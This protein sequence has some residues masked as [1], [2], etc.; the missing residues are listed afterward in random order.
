M[1]VC[2]LFFL[3]FK[4]LSC[5]AQ[6]E[7]SIC[8]GF[9]KRKAY[10]PCDRSKTRHSGMNHCTSS[11]IQIKTFFFQWFQVDPH[12]PLLK[13]K[14]KSYIML[15]FLSWAFLHHPK[16]V[17]ALFPYLYSQ[18]HPLNFLCSFTVTTDFFPARLRPSPFFSR[19]KTSQCADWPGCFFPFNLRAEASGLAFF[20][21]LASF[22]NCGYGAVT[23]KFT[24]QLKTMA[25]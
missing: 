8:F 19:A 21:F 3:K 5:L 13:Q 15:L 6:S 18:R 9:K 23:K 25:P 17:R 4:T 12:F 2:L 1:C 14:K 16:N 22:V 24:A 10:F 11:N 7:R 20:F